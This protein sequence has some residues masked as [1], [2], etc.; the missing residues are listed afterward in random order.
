MLLLRRD[1]YDVPPVIRRPIAA[2]RAGDAVGFA[3]CFDVNANLLMQYDPKLARLL[4]LKHTRTPTLARGAVSIM[5]LYERQFSIMR[6]LSLDV[7]SALKSGSTIAAVLEWQAQHI[8]TGEEFV[9]RCHHIWTMDQAGRKCIDARVANK[10][11][12][13][14]WDRLIN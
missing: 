10:I 12:T 8:A 7:L 6:I 9:T 4:K 1:V 3:E 11:L 13:P 5:R 2:F 14:Y